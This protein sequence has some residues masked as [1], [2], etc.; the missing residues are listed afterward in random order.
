MSIR[1]FLSDLSAYNEGFLSGKWIQLPLP[2]EELLQALIEVLREG[3]IA[4]GTDN[5]EEIFITDFEAE[6]VIGEYDNIERLN[7]L[8]EAMDELSD[9]D[10]LKLRFLSHEGYNERDV[11]DNGLDSYDVDI[12]DFRDNNSFTDTFELLASDFV[13][14]GLFGEIPKALE[15]YID[16]SAIARDLRMDYCE[17]QDNVIGRVA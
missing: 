11:I 7:E 15:F 17:F 2:Q 14:E 9:D 6:I 4:S 13:D 12:Y 3:E 10:L 5:H 1:I 8:A 16:Y